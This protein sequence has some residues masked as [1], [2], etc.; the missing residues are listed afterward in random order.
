MQLWASCAQ[1]DKEYEMLSYIIILLVLVAVIGYFR[2]LNKEDRATQAA[3]LRDSVT[4]V[5]A[6]TAKI[7]KESIKAAYNSGRVVSGY[8]EEQHSAAIDAAKASMEEAKAKHSGSA[9]RLGVSLGN[10]AC[11]AIYL[12]EANTALDKELKSQ[13]AAMAARRR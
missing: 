13:A 1:L 9:V 11:E 10:D 7:G 4:V 2:G 8:V 3:L 6:A 5:G 12:N